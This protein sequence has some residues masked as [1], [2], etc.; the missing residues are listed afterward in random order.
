MADQFATYPSL[1][2]KVVFITGGAS[3]I[4]AREVTHF[5][6]QGARVAFVDVDTSAARALIET[7]VTQGAPASW[8][9]HCDLRDI[10]ALRAAIAAAAAALGP[11]TALVN[12][13]ANDRRHDWEDVTPAYWDDRQAVN[14]RH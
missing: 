10:E 4:G 13:A 1:R 3:G 5:A 11:I 8:F 9:Q 2:G 12:N 14:L 7:C 6:R